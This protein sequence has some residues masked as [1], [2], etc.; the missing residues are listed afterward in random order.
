VFAF[1]P[2]EEQGALV[3]AVRKFAS[4]ELR[5]RSREA[6]ERGTLPPE[7][8]GTGWELG[9]LPGSIPEAFGGFGEHSTVTGVLAAEELAFG[10][11]SAALALTAP[12]LVAFPVLLCGSQQQKTEIL[13]EYCAEAFV[14]AAAALLE[15]RYGFDP[16]SLETRA[17]RSDQGYLLSGSKCNVP[18]AAEA[19]RMLVY[20][21]L[22]GKTEAF[23]VRK[24]TPGMV[25]TE[26]EANM[27]M[28]ACPLYSVDFVGCQVSAKERLGG[29]TGCDFGLL[30]NASRVALSA[31]AVGVAR[32]AYEFG[33]DYAKNRKAFGEAI[34]QRQ[35]IAFMLA[36]MA[37]DVEA[38][39][40]MVW[41][42]AWL[43]DQ[44][45]DATREAALAKNFADDMSLAVTDRA[46]QILGGHG[47]IRDYPVEMWLRNARGFAVMEGIAIA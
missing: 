9:L 5:S 46:V 32:A 47:Y 2:S 34:A 11:L 8:T 23:L 29:E 37:T 7:V 19:E 6:D 13:P 16:G 18:F 35:S 25:V 10:D 36:E 26:R 45:K 38:A 28:N 41:E 4:K 27:G 40:L 44:G 22:E 21:S 43:L 39:R 42:A 31:M 30:L 17:Q 12:N 20:A 1:E 24:G 14:P 15:P 33:L 3:E